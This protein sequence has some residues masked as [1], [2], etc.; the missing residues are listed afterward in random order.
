MTKLIN[1]MKIFGGIFH[2]TMQVPIYF[3]Q[4][5]KKALKQAETSLFLMQ[6]CLI[7]KSLNKPI[8]AL[9]HEIANGQELATKK[10]LLLIKQ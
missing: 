1:G 10:Q 2:F 3:V 6:I 5:I 9:K 8:R 7:L 4:K